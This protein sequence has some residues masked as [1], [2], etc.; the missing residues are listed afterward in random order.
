[1]SGQTK[2]SYFEGWFVWS[3]HWHVI[4]YLI[5]MSILLRAV[6]SYCLAYVSYKTV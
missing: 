4:I 2:E 3:H 1:M 6:T 5:M